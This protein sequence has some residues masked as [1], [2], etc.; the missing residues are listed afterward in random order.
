MMMDQ[1]IELDREPEWFNYHIYCIAIMYSSVRSS[2]LE[3]ENNIIDLDQFFIA[4]LTFIRESIPTW[5]H[6]VYS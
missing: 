4:S 1:V 2:I 3:L 6:L 5:T